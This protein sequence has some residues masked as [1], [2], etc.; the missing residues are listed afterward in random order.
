MQMY[1]IF[2]GGEVFEILKSDKVVNSMCSISYKAKKIHLD[3]VN[4]GKVTLSL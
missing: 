3:I 4:L 2:L 1:D